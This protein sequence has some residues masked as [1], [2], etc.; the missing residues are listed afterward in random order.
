MSSVRKVEE[1]RDGSV[2][3]EVLRMKMAEFSKQR[4]WERFHSPRNLLLA[5]VYILLILNFIFPSSPLSFSLSFYLSTFFS[6]DDACGGQS[7]LIF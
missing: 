3:L 5:L 4:N 6:S 2:S 1:D 7:E